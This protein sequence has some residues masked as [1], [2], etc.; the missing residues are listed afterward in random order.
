MDALCQHWHRNDG[1]GF[2]PKKESAGHGLRNIRERAAALGGSA[3][4]EPRQSHGT[5]VRLR[6]P[7]RSIS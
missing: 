5:I 3:T 7:L 1:V 4:I 2:D 6:V